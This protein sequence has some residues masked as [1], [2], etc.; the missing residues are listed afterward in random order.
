MGI[1]ERQAYLQ[2]IRIRYRRARKKVKVTILNEFCAVCGYNRKYA[3][4]LLNQRAPARKKRRRGRKPIYASPELRTALKRIWFATDQMCSKKLKAAIPLWL[5]H[6]ES[7]YQPLTPE[8]HARLL[9]VSAATIDRLLKPVR[10][11]HG[12]KGH[13][14][15]RPGSL[16]KNQIPIR[17]HFWDVSQP[18]FMEA[19]TVAHCGNS[20]A[21]SFIWSLTMTDIHTTWTES[22][23]TWDKGAQGVLAQIQDIEERL[24]FA[25]QGFD[26]DNGSEFL[27][28]HLVRYF[29]DHPSVTS[30]TRSRPYRKNDNAHVE[31]KNWSHVRQLFGYDRL[32]DRQLLPLMNDLY[33]QEWSQYQNHFCPSMK[34]LEK[35]RI[36]SKYRKKY[37]TPQTPYQRVLASDQITDAAKAHLKT[38][39]QSLNPF[40]LKNNIERKLRAIFRHV[41]VTSNVRQR[42]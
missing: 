8:T 13:S 5:P 32:E 3:I 31:Q 28:Y 6:Y 15:T 30:F 1:N 34:L 23:A 7:A 37:D 26:C 29:T 18:G 17:T 11:A 4:R 22:R 27:N 36:N 10:V 2:A 41:K 39:H 21:G 33:T 35:E 24:P 9:A 16:L 42:I 12:G 19:D 14:G 40:I 38:V 20:L 25:L